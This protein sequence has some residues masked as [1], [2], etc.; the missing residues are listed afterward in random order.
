MRHYVTKNIKYMPY[1]RTYIYS[2]CLFG[3][4]K[5]IFSPGMPFE[6]LLLNLK[7]KNTDLRTLPADGKINYSL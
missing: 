3:L 5:T 1:W 4:K 2:Y 6:N 7:I